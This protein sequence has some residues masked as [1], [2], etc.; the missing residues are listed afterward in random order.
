MVEDFGA[1]IQAIMVGEE[2]NPKKALADLAGR[3]NQ[4][5]DDAIAAVQKKGAKVSR[6]DWVFENWDPRKDYLPADYKGR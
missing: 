1:V 5:L 6:E 2:T 3:R 4:M